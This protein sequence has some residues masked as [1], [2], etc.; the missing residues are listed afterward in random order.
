MD[1][2]ILKLFGQVAGIAGLSIGVVLLL[3][4]DVIRK[5]VFSRLTREHSYRL[6]RLVIVL[7]WSI[8][9][10]G[11]FAWFYS[12][13]QT[14]AKPANKNDGASSSAA[15]VPEQTAK[16]APSSSQTSAIKSAT[17]PS[18]PITTSDSTTKPPFRLNN[19]RIRKFGKAVHIAPTGPGVTLNGHSEISDNGVGIKSENPNAPITLNDNS[20]MTGNRIAIDLIPPGNSPP[21]ALPSVNY[22]PNGIA[23]SGTIVGNPTV[24]NNFLQSGVTY[25]YNGTVK[26]T[27]SGGRINIE[28]RPAN[29]LLDTVEKMKQGQNA[30][31]LSEAQT[32]SEADPQWATPHI[33]AAFALLNMGNIEGAKAEFKAAKK[34]VPSGYEFEDEYAPHFKHLEEVIQRHDSSQGRIAQ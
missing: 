31:A 3:F 7:T 33:E 8:G 32:L 29:A 15:G 25:S 13:T 6:L 23:N 9:V 24:N 17:Q 34:L 5:N 11:I 10:L 1:L 12:N 18:S 16:T 20:K 2:N 30:E 26:K 21:R 4:R 19:V 14:S 27:I 22:A 28:T